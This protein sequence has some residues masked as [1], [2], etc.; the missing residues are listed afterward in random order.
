MFELSLVSN[1][2]AMYRI[3]RSGLT[4]MA[5]AAMLPAADPNCPAYPSVVRTEMERS[6]SLD[7][8]FQPYSKSA[9]TRSR[10]VSTPRLAASANVI[11]Q[12]IFG[13]MTAD[14]VDPAPRTSDAEFPRRI[15]LDLTGRI[16]R[17]SR[18]SAF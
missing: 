7:C 17:P 13:K 9:K 18:P 1:V 3:I 2:Y 8:E 5:A 10:P 16:P 15:Y 6:L 14:G 12:L 4:V 11:D